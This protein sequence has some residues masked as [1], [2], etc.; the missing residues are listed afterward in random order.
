[1][2]GRCFPVLVK[3]L[4]I[5]NQ[6]VYPLCVEKLLQS[7]SVCGAEMPQLTLRMTCDGSVVSMAR[8]YCTMAP[9]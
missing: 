1:M 6:I 4:Q 3:L 7:A 2:V 9:S 8:M 5:Q